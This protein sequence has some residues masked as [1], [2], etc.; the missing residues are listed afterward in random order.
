MKP[1]HSILLLVLGL[2]ASVAH[3]Q[4]ALPPDEAHTRGTQVPDVTL[5]GE[6]STTFALSSLAGKPIVVSPIFTECPQTCPMI[7][8]NLR[9]ALA[10]IG[11]PGVGY[12]VLTVSFDPA[13][14]PAQLR[15]YRQKMA[16]PA[17]WKL[18]VA[19]PE[20]LSRLLDA[21]DFNYEKLPEGGFVHANVV[22]ILTPTL[23]VS[24]YAHGVTYEAKDLRRALEIATRKS[25]LV[26][27]YRP[28]M[29]LAAVLAL[30][31]ATTILVATRKKRPQPA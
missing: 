3:A 7:T 29:A 8:G 12:Q 16:L 11:E 26:Y 20:N 19:S 24:S 10:A 9:D 1:R 5:I 25:S 2:V 15:E 23:V 28:Y 27:H 17:G 6:D 31:T 22:A 18:A 30:A 4:M 13:D 14:G 21:I